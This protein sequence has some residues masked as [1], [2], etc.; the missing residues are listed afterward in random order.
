[1]TQK[2]LLKENF[3]RQIQQCCFRDFVTVNN[4]ALKLTIQLLPSRGCCAAHLF[5]F[6]SVPLPERPKICTNVKSNNEM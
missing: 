1:M 2:T 6:G 4:Q 5:S 3:T